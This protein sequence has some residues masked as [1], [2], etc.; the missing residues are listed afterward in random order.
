MTGWPALAAANRDRL[1]HRYQ[2]C[3]DDIQ[4][5][6]ADYFHLFCC[7]WKTEHKQFAMTGQGSRCITWIS[8]QGKHWRP[9]AAGFIM[10]QYSMTLCQK[11]I[12]LFTIGPKP[13]R[14][15]LMFSAECQCVHLFIRD[16][17]LRV[18]VWS[19]SIETLFSTTWGSCEYCDVL[20]LTAY[21]RVTYMC[22]AKRVFQLRKE[23][24][25]SY[26]V[27]CIQALCIS[28]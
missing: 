23:Y 27:D 5:G 3:T 16:Q 21:C 10:T 26:W 4:Q 2:M 11:C 17:L 18:N 15:S 1:E 14:P 12:L 8:T 25:M 6:W 22:F 13:A 19:Y 28:V 9:R 7:S 20:S 24:V